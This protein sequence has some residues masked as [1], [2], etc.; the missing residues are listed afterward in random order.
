MNTYLE[1]FKA[2]QLIELRLIRGHE[3]RRGWLRSEHWTPAV[4]ETLR[5]RNAEGFSIFAS[6]NP[7]SRKAG[8]ES[9]VTEVVAFHADVDNGAR[10]ACK[11]PQGGEAPSPS[12]TVNSGHGKH[13]YWYLAE[14]IAVTDDN[15]AQLKAI[16]RGLAL[17]VGG[18]PACCDLS[19][20]LRV[21]GFTNHKPPASPVNIIEATEARYQLEDLLPFAVENGTG[22][23]SS[24]DIP[25]IALPDERK[26]EFYAIRERTPDMSR[27]W[28][29]EIGDGSSDSRFVL[30]RLLL[31]SGFTPAE[32]LAVVCSRKWWNRYTKRHRTASEVEADARR[33][34]AKLTASRPA[35]Q[36]EG[37][38][39]RQLE[40]CGRCHES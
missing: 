2:E 33:I 23:V 21:P 15:R 20:I 5:Q 26:R 9:S 31:E 36:L 3:V 25:L 11:D 1:R 34:I 8:G 10:S 22:Q 6:V 24:L 35:I 39:L 19:R 37:G 32:T 18:D 4:E 27:A 16:N 14:P 29:G 28:R 38:F 30:A 40:I 7:R 12:L 13:L 17:A